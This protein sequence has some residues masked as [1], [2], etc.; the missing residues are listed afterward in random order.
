MEHSFGLSCEVTCHWK[1][2][3]PAYEHILPMKPRLVLTRLILPF[4]GTIVLVVIAC[5]VAIYYAGERNVQS[6][7]VNE[8]NRLAGLVRGQLAGDSVT[9]EQ[10]KQIQ[11]LGRVLDTRITLIDRKGVVLLDTQAD[12]AQME[13]HNG[14]P[15]VMDAR[16][17]GFGSSVRHSD[18][19]HQE[20]VYVATPLDASR[21]QG[22]ILRLSYPQSVWPQLDTTIWPVLIAATAAALLLMVL[23]SIVLRRQWIGPIRELAEATDRMASGQW[24]ARVE[25]KGAEDLRFFSHRL[26]L[27]AEHAERQLADLNHQ[28]ADLQALVDSLPDPIFLIDVQG[29]IILLNLSAAKLV[30]MPRPFIRGW[31]SG[32]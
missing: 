13:N 20:A 16:A 22:I 7:Q 5:G 12:A 6:E 29:R 30:Q 21:P 8:L 27:A 25:A 18:T 19:I 14:R 1:I 9:A 32:W 26:N 28:R 11:D 23:L 10:Q 4:A 15:E 3:Y 24:D 2:D 31:G 17:K